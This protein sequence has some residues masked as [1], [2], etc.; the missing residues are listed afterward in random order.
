MNKVSNILPTGLSKC[1][2]KLKTTITSTNTTDTDDVINAVN[3]TISQLAAGGSSIISISSSTTSTTSS[4][5]H[6]FLS[7]NNK[8]SVPTRGSARAEAEALR[9]LA[10][11]KKRKEK[12]IKFLL[13]AIYTVKYAAEL[14]Y[15][16][17]CKKLEQKVTE[18][19]TLLCTIIDFQIRFKKKIK[20]KRRKIEKD[21]LLVISY[22][23]RK[24]KTN[25]LILI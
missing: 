18:N 16:L 14:K 1:Q 5:R 20:E 23:F 24:K 9:V 10:E 13:A 22:Y 12:A 7:N 8:N 6:S 11:E 17:E 3:Q 15:K 2:D 25:F 4:T 19:L 21:A